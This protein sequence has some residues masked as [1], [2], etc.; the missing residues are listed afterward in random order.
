MYVTF[1]GDAPQTPYGALTPAKVDEGNV[2]KDPHPFLGAVMRFSDPDADTYYSMVN[3][4]YIGDIAIE[5]G[6][7]QVPVLEGNDPQ[8]Y[9]D[10]QTSKE[11][12]SCEE[13]PV[14]LMRLKRQEGSPKTGEIF[15]NTS[16]FAGPTAGGSVAVTYADTTEWQDVIVDFSGNKNYKG[17]LL[18]FRFVLF[19]RLMLIFV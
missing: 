5:D 11:P 3:A 17:D 15:F 1:K 4:L 10:I 13:Y 19:N 6:K 7:L 8:F 16:E 18:S 9:I 14:M 2:N 12:V